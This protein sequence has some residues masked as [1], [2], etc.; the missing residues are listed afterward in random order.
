MSTQ[1]VGRTAVTP[2]SG[3]RA[4]RPGRPGR[5]PSRRRR[6]CTRRVEGTGVRTTVQV[7]A[8][9]GHVGAG[10]PGATTPWTASRWPPSGAGTPPGAVAVEVAAGVHVAASWDTPRCRRRLCGF[11]KLATRRR[12]SLTVADGQREDP[13]GVAGAVGGSVDEA[14]QRRGHVGVERAAHGI[15]SAP[16]AGTPRAGRARRA[17][18]G[19]EAELS[20]RAPAAAGA[21]RRFATPPFW[22]RGSGVAPVHRVAHRQ[23]VPAVQKQ[24]VVER[25]RSG[26]E[27]LLPASAPPSSVAVDPRVATGADRRSHRVRGVPRLDVAELRLVSLAGGSSVPAPCRPARLVRAADPG[28][29]R[30]RPSPRM[31]RRSRSL[32][33]P[34]RRGPERARRVLAPTRAVGGDEQVSDHSGLRRQTTPGGRASRCGLT[35]P[36]GRPRPAPAG[37]SWSR[38]RCAPVSRRRPGSRCAPGRR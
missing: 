3:R 35:A 29:A 23:P 18:G 20:R 37:R 16:S 2:S 12:A 27:S 9:E 24:A 19:R 22:G 38:C 28:D 32:Q 6:R 31:R 26:A 5:T 8:V 17:R 10:R 7:P 4:A 36:A 13:A 1:R 21:R 30:D 34:G 15:G 11:S 33:R 14:V 25:V